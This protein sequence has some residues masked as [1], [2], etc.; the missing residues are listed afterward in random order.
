M[1][2]HAIQTGSISVKCSYRTGKGK[3]RILRLTSVLLDTQFCEIPV[4]AWAIEHPEGIIVIDTGLT[5]QMMNPEYFPAPQ[6]IYWETQYRFHITPEQEIGPQLLARGISPNDVRWVVLTHAHFDHTQALYT[7]PNSEIIFYRQEY[8]DVETY[9]SAHFDFPSKWPTWLNPRLIDYL[10]EPVGPFTESFPLTR[11]GDVRLIPTPG[12]TNTHQSVILQDQGLTY[13]FAGDTSFDMESLQQ[14]IIDAPAMNSD[15]TLETRQ[16]II[17]L[18]QQTPLIYLPTH[19]PA[20]DVRLQQ[21]IPLMA[22]TPQATHE[23]E[24]S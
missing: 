24:A 3:L 15:Q 23:T 19:D 1:K 8:E 18:G 11:A 13:F 2:I 6:R 16:K 21:H 17:Q 10:P 7:F 20:N 9:R 12:H 5:S 4:Y 14:G 22:Q